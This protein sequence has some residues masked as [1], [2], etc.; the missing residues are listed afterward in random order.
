M[1]HL[2]IDVIVTTLATNSAKVRRNAIVI[3]NAKAERAVLDD[4]SCCLLTYCRST[5][6][7]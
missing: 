3:E 5:G 7:K 4:E 2:K 6:S 1:S